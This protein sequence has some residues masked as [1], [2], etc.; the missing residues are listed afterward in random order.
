MVYFFFSFVI[1]SQ[2]PR[3]T[4]QHTTSK[5]ILSFNVLEEISQTHNSY[6]IE[7]CT[8]KYSS[9]LSTSQKIHN[10]QHDSF[11]IR[12]SNIIMS[13]WKAVNLLEITTHVNHYTPNFYVDLTR[14]TFLSY[15]LEILEQYWQFTQNKSSHLQHLIYIF[16]FNIKSLFSLHQIII[17]LLFPYFLT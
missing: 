1:F 17:R 10:Y 5:R 15:D 6:H 13:I 9:L 14:H 2:D 3:H 4:I 12:S 8:W 16:F 7:H 11:K